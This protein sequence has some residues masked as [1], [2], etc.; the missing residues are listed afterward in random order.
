MTATL[1]N[2]VWAAPQHPTFLTSW[3][4]TGT[5]SFDCWLRIGLS[6][7]LI[8]E[9]L[10]PLKFVKRRYGTCQDVVILAITLLYYYGMIFSRSQLNTCLDLYHRDEDIH[11]CYDGVTWFTSYFFQDDWYGTLMYLGEKDGLPI[12]TFTY[13]IH[14][15]LFLAS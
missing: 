13:V 4:Y 8:F 15:L 12:L 7:S 11:S 5:A 9:F 6:N 3:R 2:C 14:S 10:V 1:I